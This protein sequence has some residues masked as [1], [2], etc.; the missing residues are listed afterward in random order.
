MQP[1]PNAAEV[2][3]GAGVDVSTMER[4]LV[5][6]DTMDY[7]LQFWGAVATDAR[8]GIF[9][10]LCWYVV[11]HMQFSREDKPLK[12]ILIAKQNEFIRTSSNHGFNPEFL[13]AYKQL[14]RRVQA[15]RYV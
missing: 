10:L 3:V 6:F 5:V 8:W 2:A 4:K 12:Q 9:Y 14:H 1:P 15:K 13:D 11:H 7:L